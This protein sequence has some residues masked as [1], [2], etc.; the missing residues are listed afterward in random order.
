MENILSK[1]R[2]ANLNFPFF[3]VDKTNYNRSIPLKYDTTR[4]NIFFIN[5]KRSIKEKSIKEKILRI[6]TI[7]LSKF[8][9]IIDVVIK[10]GDKIK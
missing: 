5:L 1:F 2:N 8:L 4:I 7:A 6:S 9:L 10:A 3:Q